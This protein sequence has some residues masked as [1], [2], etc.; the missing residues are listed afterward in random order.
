M[1]VRQRLL[2]LGGQYGW[3]L[4]GVRLKVIRFVLNMCMSTIISR[5]LMRVAV[6]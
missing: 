5:V 6:N 4:M 3:L 2:I 1:V